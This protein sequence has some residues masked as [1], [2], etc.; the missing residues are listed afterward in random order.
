VPSATYR[1]HVCD[2]PPVRMVDPES[3]IQATT[4]KYLQL[5]PNISEHVTFRQTAC[6]ESGGSHFMSFDGEQKSAPNQTLFLFWLAPPPGE[7]RRR[8]RHRR[9]RVKE[10]ERAVRLAVSCPQRSLEFPI[11]QLI[12][13]DRDRKDPSLDRRSDSAR[14]TVPV[15][16]ISR[17]AIRPSRSVA[18]SNEFG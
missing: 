8:R 6:R 7:S 2:S 9:G 18:N 5:H 13:R 12:R 3:I 10:M 1:L 4:T 17:R 15:G 14:K 16:S 11:S